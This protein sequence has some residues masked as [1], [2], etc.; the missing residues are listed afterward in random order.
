MHI[1]LT[2]YFQGPPLKLL[3]SV[4]TAQKNDFPDQTHGPSIEGCNKSGALT[5]WVMSPGDFFCS[6]SLVR[7]EGNEHQVSGRG[8]KGWQVVFPEGLKRI[9][10]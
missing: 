10:D 8:L 5:F 4:R 1:L 2:R 7:R 9:T 6:G 3:K